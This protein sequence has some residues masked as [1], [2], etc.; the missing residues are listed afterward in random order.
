M[1][2]TIRGRLRGEGLRFAVLVARWNA[3]ITDRLRDGALGALRRAGVRDRDVTVVEVPGAFE[4]PAAALAA[5]RSGSFDAIVALGCL[6]KGETR[7]DEVIADACARGLVDASLATGVPAT[8]GVITADTI[9]QARARSDLSRKAGRKKGHKGVE[10]AEAAVRLAD[11]LR[12]LRGG[13]GAG[14]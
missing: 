11:A 10:A 3:P 1:P 8:F 7:H 2:R 4:L 12:S 14:S 5:G 9:E 13:E 6:V